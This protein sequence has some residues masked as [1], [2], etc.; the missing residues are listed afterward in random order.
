MKNVLR[1]IIISFLVLAGCKGKAPEAVNEFVEN[2]SKVEVSAKEV[3]NEKN[4]I[5]DD[6]KINFRETETIN[7]V[8]FWATWCPGCVDELP[9]IQ[10]LQEQYGEIVNIVTVNTTAV[11]RAGK[12]SVEKFLKDNNYTFEVIYDET[13]RISNYYN[14]SYIP[15]NLIYD[16]DGSLI[17]RV[18]EFNYET[19]ENYIMDMEKVRDYEK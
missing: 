6:Y 15:L 2:E 1:V 3:I 5:G 19:I 7:L 11:E 18:N 12:A 10:K 4:F 16:N 9:K 17:E 8:V 14:V 13:G